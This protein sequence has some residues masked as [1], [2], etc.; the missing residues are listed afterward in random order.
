MREQALAQVSEVPI[1]VSRRRDA[2]VDLEDVYIGPRQG[3]I[4]EL[5][6][7]LPRGVTAADGHDE[8]TARGAG[9]TRL[10]GGEC[11]AGSRDRV[12]IGQSFDPHGCLTIGFSQPQ[13]G[14]ETPESTSFGPQ[15]P[16]SYS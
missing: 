11:G 12:G 2:L 14:G 15:V 3:L 10:L 13:E 5:T 16:G 8:A 9:R 7:H 1:G 6:Q 4:G